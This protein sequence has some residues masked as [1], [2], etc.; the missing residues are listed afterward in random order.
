M[1][2]DPSQINK[3]RGLLGDALTSA[4]YKSIPNLKRGYGI[5]S[6]GGTDSRYKVHFEPTKEQLKLFKGGR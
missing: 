1:L 5:V 3:M 4:D 6:T 2:M